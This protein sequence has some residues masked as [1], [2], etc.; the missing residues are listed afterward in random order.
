MSHA[1]LIKVDP[2]AAL[3]S[4]R[5][6]LEPLLP[7]H[8]ARTFALWQ[9]ERLYTFTPVKP[10]TELD[11]LEARYRKLATRRSPDGTEAWL[12]WFAREKVS[13][14]YV[15]HIQVTVGPDL[16]ARLGYFTFAPHWR[17]GYAY[18]GCQAVIH[19][20]LERGVAELVAEIDTR[21]VASIRLIEKLG[22]RRIAYVPNAGLIRGAESD[23]YRYT[24]TMRGT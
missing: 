2:E 3:E 13:G 24:L 18:E 6:V 22:F 8:A 20:L 10:P 23:D 21:N 11:S 5:L 14:E 7:H 9:D 16:S 17:R 19:W 12:N 15:A 1:P 4:E